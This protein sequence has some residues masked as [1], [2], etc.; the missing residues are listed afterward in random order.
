MKASQLLKR[1]SIPDDAVL[2]I[3][4]AEDGEL[5]TCGVQPGYYNP[6]QMLALIEKHKNDA[7][8]VRFIAD[9][10]ETGDE[11]DDGFAEMLRTNLHNPSEVD[12]IVSICR[13]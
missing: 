1:G 10:L 3:P 7:E 12:R 5:P 9:M 2:L 6:K 11:K 4:D 8:A 13:A